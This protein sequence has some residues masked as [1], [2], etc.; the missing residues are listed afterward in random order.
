MTA[1]SPIYR[2]EEEKRLTRKKLAL[3]RD[4]RRGQWALRKN[5]EEDH[6]KHVDIEDQTHDIHE[7]SNVQVVPNNH[8][9]NIQRRKLHDH[10]V[11]VYRN[12]EIDNLALI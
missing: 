11:K 1:H 9:R 3:K 4:P 6:H 12:N 5:V 7:S 2:T 8:S 10:E